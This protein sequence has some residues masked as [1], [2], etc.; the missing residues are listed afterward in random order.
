MISRRISNR[1]FTLVELLVVIAI[2]GILV[3]L[4]LPAVQAAREAARRAQCQNRIRQIGI[5]CQ[6][7]HDTR[8]SFPPA[9]SLDFQTGSTT[10]YT[11]WGYIVYVLPFMEE[12]NLLS[13]LDLKQFWN[14]DPPN[15]SVLYG[16]QMPSLRCPSST[17][18]ELTFT[19]P[20]GQNGAT[21]L[22]FLRTHYMGVMGAKV[23]CPEPTTGDPD[24]TYIMGK[25]DCSPS[26]G[27]GSAI[28]GAIIMGG[29]VNMRRISDGTSHTFCVGEISWLCGPQRIWAVGSASATVPDRFNYSA[30]NVMY[31]LNT[32]Y[33][34]E[35]SAPTP[36]PYANN[37]M[38]FGSL[39]PG[40]T[41]FVM[42]DASVQ[43]VSENVDLATLRALASRASA[44]ALSISF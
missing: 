24:K 27:G 25:G 9:T 8:K 26:Q 31:P 14:V 40:G 18:Q 43:F 41:H 39:H 19:D 15:A 7:Y 10:K 20:P 35:P 36:S 12:Q 37:D 16:T 2:I 6:N 5:S 32:A 29:G 11:S 21:E 44:E 34:A 33:R 30:K 4:L 28:N 42:C 17:D 1:A 23:S 38:S 22:S 13:K 3:A